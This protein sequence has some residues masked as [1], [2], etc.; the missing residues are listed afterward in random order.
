MTVYGHVSILDR[1]EFVRETLRE[2][3]ESRRVVAHLN[4]LYKSDFERLT[5]FRKWM[6][7]LRARKSSPPEKPPLRR[8]QLLAS[9]PRSSVSTLN[10]VRSQ[11]RLLKRV[12]LSSD[13]AV[14]SFLA[15]SIGSRRWPATYG[16][17]GP[18][19]T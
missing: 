14:G 6:M 12:A 15:T 11:V 5:T 8:W 16:A 13:R 17:L 1:S 19:L 10:D 4:A 18:P 2:I 3:H 7:H 9:S